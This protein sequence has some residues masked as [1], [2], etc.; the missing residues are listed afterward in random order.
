MSRLMGHKS[1]VRCVTFSPD[2][3]LIASGGDDEIVRICEG[4]TVRLYTR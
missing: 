3:D 1:E 4:L 2:G